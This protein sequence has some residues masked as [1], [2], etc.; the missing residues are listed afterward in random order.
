LDADMTVPGTAL[1]QTIRN[2]RR[3]AVTTIG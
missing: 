2:L 1:A 3:P